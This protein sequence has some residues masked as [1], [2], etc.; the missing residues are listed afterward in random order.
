MLDETK[1]DKILQASL[2]EFAEYG[3]EKASTDRISQRAEVSK[4][5]IF[6]YFGSK[7]KLYMITINNCIDDMFEEYKNVKTNNMDFIGNIKLLM[8]IKYDFF[9]KNPLYYRIMLNGFYN[10]PAELKGE[11]QKRYFELSKIGMGIIADMIGKLPLKKDVSIDNVITVISGIQNI[12]ENKYL[13]R[14]TNDTAS[15]EG[16]YKIVSDEFMNL[17]NIVM[18]GIIDEK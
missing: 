6:H 4:G 17:L 1:R 15:F 11:L 2:E 13:Y 14:F 10:S 5:L 3:Y 9:N 12:L 8:K 16:V 7:S 18:Y